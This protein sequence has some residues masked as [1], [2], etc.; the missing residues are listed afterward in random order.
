MLTRGTFP[1][2]SGNGRQTGIAGPAL[3]NIGSFEVPMRSAKL[4]TFLCLLLMGMTTAVAQR[5]PSGA[6]RLANLQAPA[7]RSAGQGRG[8]AQGPLGGVNALGQEL[9]RP[10]APTGPIPRL[11]DGTVDLGDGVWYGGGSSGDI[12]AGLPRGESLPLLPWAKELRQHRSMHQEEDPT[13]FCLPAGVPRVTPYPSRFVQNYTIKPTHMFILYEGTIHTYRQIFMDG[14]KH[15]AELE[16][17]WLGH[18]T[19]SWDKDTLV[20]D[21]A[22]YNDRSWFDHTG[23]PHTEQLHTTERWTRIDKG[24]MVNAVTIDDPGAFSK[25]FTVTF[26]ATL[27][28]AGDELMEG[29]CQENNQFGVAGGHQFP[30]QGKN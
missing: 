22:G 26:N 1:Y 6:T 8:A 10:S 20:I 16:P 21:T 18:S 28:P 24:H 23:T 9:R 29:F 30:S 12:A 3:I 15:P 25:P 19:G 2:A 27:A 7:G 13:N 17:T 5:G 14:R 11:S 4:T